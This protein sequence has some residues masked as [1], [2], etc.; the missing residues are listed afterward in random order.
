[1]VQ[2]HVVERIGLR[3]LHG[4]L[5]RDALQRHGGAARVRRGAAGVEGLEHAGGQRQVAA[6]WLVGC[7][8]VRLVNCSTRNVTHVLAETLAPGPATQRRTRH[9]FARSVAPIVVRQR[10]LHCGPGMAAS[11]SAG[12][13]K[14]SNV[15]LPWVSRELFFNI[16]SSVSGAGKLG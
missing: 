4:G 16:Q 13:S 12:A 1:M 8:S 2:V 15:S 6:A 9:G 3:V 10:A 5:A 11:S 14:F 7:V